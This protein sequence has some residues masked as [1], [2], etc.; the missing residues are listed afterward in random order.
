MAEAD[1]GLMFTAYNLRR[2]MNYPDKIK[3]GISLVSQ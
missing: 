2:L 3:K 1:V